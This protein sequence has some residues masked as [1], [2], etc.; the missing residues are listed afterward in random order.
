M[1]N[2]V[3]LAVCCGVASSAA[4]GSAGKY[5]KGAYNYAEVLQKSMYFYDAQRSG[6]LPYNYRV[7]WRGDSALNDGS[8]VGLDLTGGFYDAGDHVKFGFPMAYS[9]TML[10]WGAI[11]YPDA[12]KE[13]QQNVYL[14]S[15]LRYGM[16]Y[17][18]RCHIRNYD[19]STKAFYGQVGDGNADHAYWGAPETMTM[20][21][22]AMKIDK[23]NP[24]TELAAETAAAM[25]ATSI[26]FANSDPALA[27]KLIDHAKALYT[28]ADTYR[29]TYHKSLKGADPFYKSWSGYEDELI[30]GALWLYRATGETAYL[31]K[32]K[33]SFNALGFTLHDRALDWDNK[34]Y[35]TYVLFSIVD[36]GQA[37]RTASEKWLDYWAASSGGMK[38]TPDGLSWLQKWGSL[39]YAANT[40]FCALVY[41]DKVNDPSKKYSTYGKSQIDYMLGD[42]NL[43]RSFVCGFGVNPPVKPHHRSSHGSTTDNINNPVNSKHVLYGA[44]VGGPDENGNYADVRSD[45]VMNEVAMDYNAGF[46]GALAA[47]YSEYG[48]Y[49]LNNISDQ[50]TPKKS[51]DLT[52]DNTDDVTPDQSADLDVVISAGDYDAES[53]PYNANR[54]RP[55]GGTI[56]YIASGTWVRYNDFNFG[57]GVSRI[58]VSAATPNYGG[59]IEVRLGSATGTRLGSVYVRRTGSWGTFRTFAANLSSTTGTQDLY[60]VF[61]GGSGGLFNLKS[62]KISGK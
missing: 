15:T 16:D 59:R 36:G 14:M 24:G 31:Q 40:A 56:G 3:R 27:A 8:D 7:S 33:N 35:G 25:A 19:G 13:T 29:Q 30:W 32:A 57:N 20:A 62:F 61:K 34:F 49:T 23:N 43:N 42:N 5:Q 55:N 4:A 6:D 60:L 2:W 44:L 54:I 53:D 26:V 47:L 51:D 41:A 37:Y 38:R 48:G 39:R 17:L 22:P 28:F 9:F 46:T 10:A 12:Y 50:T 11:E 18:M 58:E 1:K 52:P 45:H 21:R